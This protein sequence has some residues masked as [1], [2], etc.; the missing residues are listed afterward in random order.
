VSGRA[1]SSQT[2]RGN[3][4]IGLT[5][6]SL[7][8]GFG[9]YHLGRERRGA[10]I[11]LDTGGVKGRLRSGYLFPFTGASSFEI[12]SRLEVLI[13]FHRGAS[14]TARRNRRFTRYERGLSRC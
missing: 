11:A 2:C 10:A 1:V 14:S 7:P 9:S 8:G 12:F 6:R 13:F 3:R 4:S 5:S